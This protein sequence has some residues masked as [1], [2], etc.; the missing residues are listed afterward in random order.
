ML[1]GI[2][3]VSGAFVAG[4]DAGRAYNTFPLMNGQLIPDDY[5]ALPGLCNAFEN[6]AAVQLHHRALAVSTL[7]AVGYLWATGSK[8]PL[9]RPARL[10]LHATAAMTAVQVCGTAF[11]KCCCFRWLSVAAQAAVVSAS[12]LLVTRHGCIGSYALPNAHCFPLG[13]LLVR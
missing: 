5:W 13:Q 6:T 8:L 7:A 11:R 9:P 4:L 10:L 3:A 12:V 1:V 2:T